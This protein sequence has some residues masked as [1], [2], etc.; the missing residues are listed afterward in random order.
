MIAMTPESIMARSN[1]LQSPVVAKQVPD[2]TYRSVA[3]G[4]ANVVKHTSSHQTRAKNRYT[5]QTQD[6]PTFHSPIS[7]G[8]P[9]LQSQSSNTRNEHPG[10]CQ[11]TEPSYHDAFSPTIWLPDAPDFAMGDAGDGAES[12]DQPGSLF[13]GNTPDICEL[14]C[15]LEGG[16]SDEKRP[17]CS[18]CEGQNSTIELDP[19]QPRRSKS[20]SSVLI[21]YDGYE[22]YRSDDLASQEELVSGNTHLFDERGLEELETTS[23]FSSDPE[24]FEN[25][26]VSE[27]DDV[28]DI[29]RSPSMSIYGE[30][31]TRS[32]VN[33]AVAIRP[34]SSPY[35]PEFRVAAFIEFSDKRS[36]RALVDHFCNVFSHLVVFG[37]DL[38]NPFQQLILPL[39]RKGSP[40]MNA[41]YAL[42]SAHLE[43]RGV[44][45]EEKSLY[46]HNQAT[47]GLAR[48]I[49]HI[50]ISN[51]EDV[52][53]TILLL[54]YYEAV[55]EPLQLEH[56]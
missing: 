5:S 20:P 14:G 4:Q 54:V 42:S 19:A 17:H 25:T 10:D 49:N 47:M 27:D 33:A 23:C 12:F 53:S 3:N 11:T 31:S 2:M 24:A 38:E 16:R 46:F 48:A 8:L 56:Y 43:N 51:E 39:A 29:A 13:I 52:L 32:R 21:K 1:I 55:G 50:E 15:G 36:R 7:P 41:I 26:H 30:G 40:V 22:H 34:T 37:E 28:T 35:L 18:R 45:T 9:Q 6:D 44:V